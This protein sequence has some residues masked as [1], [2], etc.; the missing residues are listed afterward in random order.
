MTKR[1]NFSRKFKLKILQEIEIKPRAEV[2]R[3]HSL[4]PN[5]I[6]RWKRELKDYADNAFQGKGILYK[7]EAQLAERDRLIGKLYAENELLKKA[8]SVLQQKRAEERKR[9]IK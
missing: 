9:C 6:S 8:N 3:E 7:Y 5:M 2:C 4:H 1:R